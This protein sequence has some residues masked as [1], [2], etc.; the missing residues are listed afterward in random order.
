MDI[1][2]CIDGVNCIN[3][4]SK[5]FTPIG[6]FYSNF[7]HTPFVCEDG[8]FASI[9]AYWYWIKTDGKSPRNTYGY[10]AKIKGKSFPSVNDIVQDKIRRAIDIKLKNNLQLIYSQDDFSLPLVHYYDY[11]NKRVEGG[12]EWIIEHIEVRREQL[13]NYFKN[14]K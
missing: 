2:K 3:V 9:E 8:E 11:G 10:D 12:H 7:S 13:Y 14:K 5:A 4:Y 1:N 6:V